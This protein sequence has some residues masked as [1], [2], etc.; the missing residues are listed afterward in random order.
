MVNTNKI[1][2]IEK[3]PS[4]VDYSEYFGFDF[5][6]FALCDTNVKRVLK[7]DLTLDNIEEIKEKYDYIILVGA[8][9]CKHVAKISSVTKYQG[10]LTDEKYLPLSNPAMLRF[11]P[12]GAP[13]FK[14]AVDSINK[15]IEGNVAQKLTE[16]LLITD[17]NEAEAILQFIIDNKDIVALDT[18]TSALYARKGYLLGLSLA[19]SDNKGYYI[20]AD[21]MS[22][23]FAEMLQHI[24]NTK[25]CVFHNA[26]FDMHFLSYHLGIEFKEDTL[27]D[28]MLMHYAL[29][30]TVG[31][32][33]LKD[34][35]IKYTDLGDYDRELEEFKRA[36]CKQHRLKLSDFT[37]DLIPNEIMYKYAATDAVATYVLYHI[38][39]KKLKEHE[40][41]YNMY[42]TLLING[43]VFLSEIEDNGVPFDKEELLKAKEELNNTIEECRKRFYDFEEVRTLEKYTEK[44]F[45][46][47]SVAQLRTLFFD[48]LNL[49][50]P[51]K[52]TDTGA[53]S[54]DAEVLKELSEL[55]ELPSLILKYKKAVKLKSTY[56]DKALLNLDSDGRL[57]TFFNLTTT[58]SGRLSSSGTLNMQ[59]IPRDD[60]LV[61]KCIKAREGYVIVSQDLVTAEMYV[62]A[63]LSG[64]KQ[65]QKVFTSGGDFHSSIA[66]MVFNLD[67]AVEQVKELYPDL[68][69]ASKAISFG[70]LYGSG[71]PKVAQVVGCS[72]EEA[73]EYI[74]L[75]FKKFSKLYKWLKEQQKFIKANGFTYSFFGRKRRLPNVF[76]EDSQ[77]A[78]HEVRSGVNALVQ[79]PASDINL[80]AGIEMQKYIKKS[81]MKSKIFALVHDSIVAEVPFN[82]L[83]KYKEKLKEF[84]QKDRGLSIPGCPIGIDVEVGQDYSFT[85]EVAYV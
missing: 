41:L 27:E 57:R 65:L 6:L 59:Q 25:T 37:Y 68:R 5:D 7:K 76:S 2:I 53:I 1:A 78:G 84:T 35:S 60:K 33:G 77:V 21:A 63:V 80:L 15:Y 82:E 55:H 29:D 50:V 56:I 10:Y 26:K 64:D 66:H 12:E 73:K 62:V 38:F 34:L 40:V 18:E 52:R 71:P 42:R 70:I 81:N 74:D 83:E 9:P 79:G 36:Y 61:K 23:K 46:P 58:T 67:C 32:H 13:A 31:S 69:Q 47:N 30:E 22:E 24:V 3:Y 72:V 54:T 39:S 4:S 85:P 19:Y 14:K 16:S 11:K 75:Y 48:I 17:E 8:D 45:N 44:V 43:T 28:T 49:P 20:I 51:S